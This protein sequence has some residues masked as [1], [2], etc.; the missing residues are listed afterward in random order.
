MGGAEKSGKRPNRWSL[1]RLFCVSAIRLAWLGGAYVSVSVPAFSGQKMIRRRRVFSSRSASAASLASGI[2]SGMKSTRLFL[3]AAALCLSLPGAAAQTPDPARPIRFARQPALSPDG[4]RLAFCYLGDLWTVDANGGNAARLTI[5]EAHDQLP[6]WSPDGKTIAFSSKREGGYDVFVMPATG[7]RATQLT[8]H[9]ADDLVQ[10]FSPDGTQVLF[11]S[12]RETTRTTSLY[13]VDIRTGA[14][15]L[16]AADDFPLN[17]AAFSPDGTQILASRGGLWFRK[18]YRGSLNGNLISFPAGGGPGKWIVKDPENER[19]P[20]LSE[21]AKIGTQTLF[22][23]SDKSGAANLWKKTLPGGKP[24]PV[25]HFVTDHLFYP[26]LARNGSRI[27]FEHD[28]GIWIWEAKTNISHEI[29]LFAPSD[30]RAN[31]IRRET[32]K[33]GLQEM[34]VS[35]DGKAALLVTHGEVFFQPL[36]TAGRDDAQRLTHTSAREQDAA[37]TP[38]GKSVLFA[39]DREGDQNLYLEDIKTKTTRLFYKTPGRADNAP[40]VSPNGKWAAFLRGFHGEELCLL[41]LDKN[42]GLV[43]KV[44]S[45]DPDID[46]LAWSPDSRFLA[47]TRT[48]SHSAGTL[49]DI[50]V[51]EAEADKAPVNVTRCP[52]INGLPKWSADGKK[53]Y[54]LSTRTGTANLWSVSL[55]EEREKGEDEREDEEKPEAKESKKG[56]KSPLSV[57]I[58]FDG[59]HKRA[60]QL[61]RSEAAVTFYTVSPDSKTVVYAMTQLGKPD[62]WRVSAK[63]GEP[64]RLTSSGETGTGLQFSPDGTKVYYLGTGGTA[65]SLTLAT[66]TVMPLPVSL[67]MEIDA[68]AELLEMFDEAW[69]KMRDA[70]YDP[71]MHGVD[72]NEVRTRYRAILPF[73]T[74]KEDFYW[75]FTL[76]MGELNASHIG[77]S[78]SAEVPPGIATASLGVTYDNDDHGSGVRVKT[79]LPKGPAILTETPLFP[80]DVILRVD[81]EKIEN[82]EQFYTLLGDK[83]GKRVELL[84]SKTGQEADAKTVKIKAITQAA[85]KALNYE[86][87]QR[88]REAVTD[89]ISGGKLGYLHL[90]AMNDENL[91]KFKRAVYGDLQ[92]KSGLILDVRFN[93]GGSI[94]DEILEILETRIFSY[95]T[96]RG[97]ARPTTAPL[98]AWNKPIIVLINE[99]S[100]SNAEVFPWAMKDLKLGKVVGVPTQGSVI[101]TGAADLIDGSTLRIPAVG[102]LTLNGIDMENHGCTPDIFVENDPDAVYRNEDKQLEAAVKELLKEIK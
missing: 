21:K 23:V 35:P 48:K 70:F 9:S 41:P 84:V 7:G 26:S 73:L 56:G 75:L 37:L 99:G 100:A 60:K 49:A 5:H 59:L 27:A 53:L 14:T 22:Y 55:E 38:D 47:F 52:G 98:S 6:A 44:L 69:R 101:G 68:R 4:T 25:T 61:T 94:A 92:S 67:K 80:G 16:A 1:P 64:V 30:D 79:V 13:T 8:F 66:Q 24:V 87:W 54:F 76:T 19:Y 58:D 74:Y 83:A 63:G 46:D 40:K 82:N 81:G 12:N 43:P 18:R 91:D 51:V 42:G 11:A 33:S 20:M 31:N 28:F 36:G 96:L 15:R 90:N 72:W 10:G 65:K 86:V 102:S 34:E 93:G 89:K 50:F 95:R 45:S 2:I 17:N 77:I 85:H 39:S 3:G 62:L 78:P 32:F 29:S 71:K 88:E 57:K 97:D